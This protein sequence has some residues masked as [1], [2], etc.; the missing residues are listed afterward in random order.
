MRGAY[1]AMRTGYVDEAWAREHHELL[2]RR[3]QGRQDPG[4]SA[5][6]G[7]DAPSSPA[8]QS[9]DRPA[10]GAIDHAAFDPDRRRDALHRGGLAL[11]KLPPCP[12]TKPRPRP[13]KPPP[14]PPARPRSMPTSCARLEDKVAAR[15]TS[16]TRRRPARTVSA[17]AA[18]RACADP[19]P[20]AYTPPGTEAAR[21]RR[22][23]FAARPRA[24]TPPSTTVPAAATDA[25]AE[26]VSGVAPRRRRSPPL[27]QRR[28]ALLRRC[29]MGDRAPPDPGQRAA[30]ARDRGA[31][32]VR[33]APP[34]LDPGRARR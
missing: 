23:A 13:P 27:E 16:P 5:V 6:R 2:V 32:R 22:R 17:D 18:H 7:H 3:H 10:E 15:S 21:G 24:T 26:A 19:G 29:A 4:R 33:R 31:R 25:G 14:R 8:G 11:A 34:H 9:E 28:V 20:F 12:T 30:D 1:S